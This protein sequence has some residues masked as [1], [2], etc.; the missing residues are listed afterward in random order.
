MQRLITAILSFSTMF[1][2]EIRKEVADFS[3]LSV[4]G[5]VEVVYTP[6]NQSRAC[7]YFNLSQIKE[8]AR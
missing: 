5:N 8:H 4:N 7:P 2:A 3:E 1:G 6:C